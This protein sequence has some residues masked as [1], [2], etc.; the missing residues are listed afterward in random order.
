MNTIIIAHGHDH[1]HA[2]RKFGKAFALGLL[3]NSAFVVIEVVNGW[4]RRL[5]GYC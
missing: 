1:G 2:S 3:L 4:W 5:N